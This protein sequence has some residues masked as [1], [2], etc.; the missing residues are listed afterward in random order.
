MAKPDQFQILTDL[1]IEQTRTAAMTFWLCLRHAIV[2]MYKTNGAQHA[3]NFQKALIL[4]VKN[5][6]ITMP[7]DKRRRRSSS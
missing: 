1:D 3:L 5:G 2:D 4:G 6:D 7:I